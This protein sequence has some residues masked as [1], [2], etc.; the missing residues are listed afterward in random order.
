M[1][2]HKLTD[3]SSHPMPS[4]PAKRPTQKKLGMFNK[5][6]QEVVRALISLMIMGLFSIVIL[7][8]IFIAIGS[9]AQQATPLLKTALTVVTSALGIVLG[10]FFRRRP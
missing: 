10:Y 8:V 7:A 3:N 6:I 1:K 2:N 9:Q 4:R 5:T